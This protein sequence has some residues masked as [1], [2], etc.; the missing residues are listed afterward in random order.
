M[1]RN[2]TEIQNDWIKIQKDL[3]DL[4]NNGAENIDQ[5]RKSVR[6]RIITNQAIDN[7]M[8]WKSY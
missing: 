7:Q 8:N 2:I 6:E 1:A 5:V 3:L 4:A